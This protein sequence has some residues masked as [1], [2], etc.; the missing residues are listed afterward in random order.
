MTDE[1][2]GDCHSF[3]EKLL[4]ERCGC[5]LF[6]FFVFILVFTLNLVVDGVHQP[7]VKLVTILMPL[8]LENGRLLLDESHQFA[9]GDRFI[10]LSLLHRLQQLSQVEQ[11]SF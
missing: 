5:P 4:F 2:L 6:A 11:N 1:T 10:L 3:G 7:N 8:P 9:R